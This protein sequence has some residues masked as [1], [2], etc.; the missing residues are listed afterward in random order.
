M[1]KKRAVQCVMILELDLLQ[2]NVF[3]FFFFTF[4]GGLKLTDAKNGGHS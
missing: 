3:F 4:F 1:W 2:R